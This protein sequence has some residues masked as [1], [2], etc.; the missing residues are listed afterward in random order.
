MASNITQ[1]AN[2]ETQRCLLRT[3]FR[4][5]S[6]ITKA[7]LTHGG[8]IAATIVAALPVSFIR[9]IACVA[10]WE[11]EDSFTCTDFYP[12]VGERLALPH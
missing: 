1:I 6:K 10:G 8:A 12:C 3:F 7:N 9:N 11:R 4:V 2:F 5:V